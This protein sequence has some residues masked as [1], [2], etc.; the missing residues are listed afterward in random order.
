MKQIIIFLLTVFLANCYSQKQSNFDV[1]LYEG[2]DLSGKPVALSELPLRRLAINVYAPTCI[3]CVKEIPALNY[4]FQE[5]NKDK[6]L[7]LYMVVDPYD[8]VPDAEPT[9][10]F[11]EL[12]PKAKAIMEKEISEKKIELPIL[13]MKRP[14]RVS[15]GDGLI[16]GR[17]ETLLFKTKPLILFYNF[18][19]PISEEKELNLIQ[20][21]NKVKFF[22]LMLGGA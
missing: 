12:Y 14:F 7:G 10:S 3:P 20:T 4:L 18:I 8:I 5:V 17:P 13:I 15:Q 21:E 2:L 1:S 6:S 9:S 22:K 19:G 16:T 11:D